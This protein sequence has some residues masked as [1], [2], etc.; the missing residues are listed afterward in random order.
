MRALEKGLISLAREVSVPYETAQWHN[1]I[2]SI[3]SKVEAMKT[4]P[5]GT[6]KIEEQQFYSEA[7]KEFMYF[8]DAWRNH[9]MHSRRTY[10]F[11]QAVKVL[12]H[13]ADFMAHIAQRLHE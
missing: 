5:H 10:D 9:V 7:A 4:L 6:H 12:A 3:A 13:V 8:K 1:I 2:E 11:G